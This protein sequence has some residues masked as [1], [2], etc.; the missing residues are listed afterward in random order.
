M[1]L[2]T[3]L[4]TGLNEWTTQETVAFALL[5]SFARGDAGPFSVVDV[6][7]FVNDDKHDAESRTFLIDEEERGNRRGPAAI[8]EGKLRQWLV[9]RSTA[10]PSKV[11]SWFTDPGQAVN[12]VAG[13]CEGRP[14]WD[15]DLRA[16]LPR[17]SSGRVSF[18]GR[19]RTRRRPTAWRT[20]N[21]LAGSRRFTRG[22]R[23][24]AATI[25]GVCSTP[26]SDCPGAWPG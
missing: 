26:L 20:R 23:A 14:L 5:G 16:S 10:T 15:P 9:V 18:D 11:E 25:H 24:C 19:K 4:S 2:P 6:V 17:S 3:S 7:R 21:W 1:E 8:A 13:L 12:Y 22:W